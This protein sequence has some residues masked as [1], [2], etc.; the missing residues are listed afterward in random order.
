MENSYHKEIERFREMQEMLTRFS[1][2][3]IQVK[4][5]ELDL[6]I[7]HILLSC[8]EFLFA[9]RAYLF[10]HN[11]ELETSSNTHEWC[12]IGVSPAK[13]NLQNIPFSDFPSFFKN[14]H[15][16]QKEV[17]VDDVLNSHLDSF[18]K[19]FLLVQDIK[20]IITAPLIDSGTCIGFIGLDYTQKC[21]TFS[22]LEQTLLNGI[23]ASL[24][25]VIKRINDEERYSVLFE[26]SPDAYLIME[27]G[28]FIDC[29]KAAIKMIGGTKNDII[30]KRPEDISP[31]Y[32]S[33]G[34]YSKSYSKEIMDSVADLG[35]I[36]FEWQHMKLD[37]T[38]F[39]VNIS[40]AKIKL[41][42][43]NVIFS[44]WRDIT[45]NKKTQDALKDSENRFKLISKHSKSVIWETDMKGKYTY[46]N[47]MSELVYGFKPD[48]LIG[49]YFYDLHP[50]EGREAYKIAGENLLNQ[51]VTLKDFENPI[52]KKDGT[53]IWVSTNGVPKTNSRGELIGYIGSDVEITEKRMATDELKKFRIISDQ[54]YFG[55]AITSLEGNILY[56]NNAFANMH[57]FMPVELI[58]KHLGIFHT[59]EQL[60]HVLPLLDKIKSEGGFDLEEV[61]HV[62]KDGS[63]FSTLMTAK[64]ISDENNIPQFLSATLIDI[65]DRKNYEKEILNL[66]QNLDRKIKERTK[67]LEKSNMDLFYAR[68]EAED[69]NKSKS[70]FLSRMSHE[71]R[72]PMNAILGFAQLLQMSDPTPSQERGINHILKSGQ[73]LLNLINEVLDI[74]KIE[75]GKLSISIE[76][77]NLNILISEVTELLASAAYNKNI[78]IETI[79][80]VT[81]TAF[82]KTDKQRLK[83]ILIN[84]MNN[85][86]KYNSINGKVWITIEP[87]FS[88][89]NELIEYKI[90]IKDN[91][92]GIDENDLGKIFSPFERI[93]AENSTV[94]GTGL[95]LAVVK[96]LAQIMNCKL[97]VQSK[98]GEGSSFS[99]QVPACQSSIDETFVEQNVESIESETVKIAGN[100]IYIEDNLTNVDLVSQVL[101]TKRPNIE[102]I[103][104]MYGND[105]LDL[106]LQHKPK[107]VLLDLHLPDIHGSEV[108]KILFSNPSTQNIPIVVISADV[109]NSNIKYLQSVGV[110]KFMSKPI[111]ITELLE[112]IDSYFQ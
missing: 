93:G 27:S 23:G 48:E 60:K 88:K 103:T 45:E 74:S 43:K 54:A 82:V 59:A 52:V 38:L 105:A 33:D 86:L 2:E 100:I 81:K 31:T 4:F 90:T 76:P 108:A 107:L 69:S 41:K 8:G 24:V 55:A 110:K 34:A 79:L 101:E 99:V 1:R 3:L 102:L 57:G 30:G 50:A 71:L 68:V 25:N 35:A 97:G 83:Q 10:L 49:K 12:N 47:E 7:N 80:K 18:T 92:K 20:S 89:E 17:I 73:H 46:L 5:S 56:V 28:I 75:S 13:E 11:N 14:L 22:I 95:G 62:K 70:E 87:V 111:I 98:L 39:W 85:A 53:L 72:T 104:T 32:Q 16:E 6:V 84:I 40:L 26:N 36:H 37:G 66:N 42:G 67:E 112:T 64:L 29:N 51:G 44:T 21:H 77:V 96:Q 106:C 91:G 19:E 63:V 65:T 15:E 109:L 61:E 9:D 58:G 94:E 78:S